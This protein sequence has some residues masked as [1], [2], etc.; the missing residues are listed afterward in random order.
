MNIQ[1]N[2]IGVGGEFEELIFQT[3]NNKRN[4]NTERFTDR[5]I[6]EKTTRTF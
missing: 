3:L 1:Y 2:T 5:I 4:K 6:R